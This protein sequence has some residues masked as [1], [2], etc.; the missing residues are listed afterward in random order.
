MAEKAIKE[1]NKHEWLSIALVV[2][3]VFAVFAVF[4]K[5]CVYRGINMSVKAE[6]GEG[7]PDAGVF[8]KSDAEVSYYSEPDVSLTEEGLYILTLQKGDSYRKVLLIVRDTQAPTA[9]AADPSIT[10]DDKTLDPAEAVSDIYDVSDYTI[11]WKT[12]PEYGKAGTYTCEVELKDAHGNARTVKT[13]VKV[14]GLI[15]V[16]EHEAGTE[17]PTLGDFMAVE[18]EGAEL[19][20]DLNTIAWETPG[21]YTVEISFDGKTFSS[22]L[23]IVDTTAPVPDLVPAAVTPGGELEASALAVGCEDVSRVSYEFKKA[24]DLSKV[25]EVKCTVVATD[26]EGNSSENEGTV[27]VCDAVC[28]FEASN[29]KLSRSAV[30]AKV[31]GMLSDYKMVTEPFELSSLGAHAVTFVKGNDT[32]IVGVTVRDTTAPTARGIDCPCST[33]YPCDAIKFVTDISDISSVKAKFVKEPDWSREGEQEVG[34][35]VFDRSGNET[36]VQAK[37][38]ITPDTTA[39]VIYAARDRYCYVG[40]AV[41][42]F[43]E[44]FAGDNADPK[45]KLTVDKSKVNSKKAGVYDVTYTAE[46]EKGNTSSVTVKFT[47]VE[48]KTTEEQLDKEV[49]RVLGEILTDGMTPA[50]QAAAIYDYVYKNVIYTGTSDKTD[51]MS[52]A[53]R[54]LTEGKGDCFT[55]YSASYALLQKVDGI[56]VLTVERLNGETQHFWCLVNLGS[57]WYHFDAC[58]VGPQNYYAFMKTTEELNRLSTY[59]WRFDAALYPDVATTPFVMDK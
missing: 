50:Q 25:G 5:L 28:E 43:K 40:E 21:D 55:F 33:G 49:E 52:E 10:I 26:S 37:A 16:L 58:N 20:T 3:L 13:E 12:E 56:R 57:G 45:P 8:M 15:D 35:I 1:K 59:F 11:R 44:V 31:G 4:M 39:P 2:I 6:L 54:G 38:V 32:K 17:R 19:V 27:L 24:P 47:F 34:I 48:K 46:D 51:W 23:R 53:Y 18:R 22:T 14:L 9:K 7:L 30:I 42:Y 36:K 41:A 29:E